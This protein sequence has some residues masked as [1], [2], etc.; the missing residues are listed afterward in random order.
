MKNVCFLLVLGAIFIGKPTQ[1]KTSINDG[2][3][4]IMQTKTNDS[5]IP[6]LNGFLKEEKYND[7]IEKAKKLEHVLLKNQQT[8]SLLISKI[9]HKKGY[10]F[11]QLEDYQSAINYFNE[12]INILPNAKQDSN[13]H[14]TILFDRSYAE[15]YFNRRTDYYKSLKK[16][17]TIISELEQPDYDFLLE[18]YAELSYETKYLGYFKEAETYLQKGYAIIKSKKN[19]TSKDVLFKH[20]AISLY[21]TWK[22]EAHILKHL[23]DLENLK[24]SKKFTP[25]ETLMY[26]VSLN[27]IADF[28]IVNLDRFDKND[29]LKKAEYYL[30]KAFKNLDKKH[31]KNSYIQ[32]KFNH[33]KLLLEKD[34]VEKVLKNVDELML[35]TK[36]T[37]TRR[38]F[39]YAMQAKVFFKTKAKNKSEKALFQMASA[40]HND[41]IQLHRDYS[42]FKPSLT[43]HHSWLLVELAD[44]FLE[45][46][47]NDT[48]I[49]KQANN[50]YKLGLLQF[51]NCYWQSAFN[52]LNKAGYSKAMFGILS[53][54]KFNANALINIL[55][56]IEN[57]E[58]RLAWK[59]FLNNRTDSNIAI[60]DSLRYKELQLRQTMVLA[61]QKNDQ[62]LYLTTKQKLETFNKLLN[63]NYP[64]IASFVYNNFS[65]EDFK[66]QLKPHQI[67]LRYKKFKDQF[68]VFII[69]KTDVKME[70]LPTTV[71]IDENIK[72][73]LENLSLLKV[74]K[75]SAKAL[76]QI[77][78][79][80][81]IDEYKSVIIIPDG[82]LHHLPFETLLTNSDKFLLEKHNISYASHL[83]FVN[84]SEAQKHNFENEL[85]VFS[86]TYNLN[87]ETNL[88]GATN[89]SKSINK[90]FK[91]KLFIGD[92]ALKSEF[93][94]NAQNANLLHLAM[95]ANL[96]DENPELSYF[97]FAENEKDNKMHLEELYA[98]SLN[99]ELAV[100]SACNTGK[101]NLENPE[102]AVSLKRAFVFAGVPATVSSLWQVPDKET[103]GLMV[104][105]YKNLNKGQYK[106]EALRN[107]K[108]NYLKTT[109]DKALKHP[110][111][112]AGFVVSGDVSAIE[113]PSN[114]TLIIVLIAL[115]LLGL[116][117]SR[118]KL[119][120]L[121]K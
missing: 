36:K 18:I 39:L 81:N 27:L 86:P 3:K 1:A 93:I 101:I 88:E 62:N 2:L 105:F 5:I 89:E 33:N 17:A 16:S 82:I 12:A 76:S 71:S 117:L 67:V 34:E 90:I 51:K 6:I 7:L 24:K 96:N 74:Y 43:L 110:F 77:L 60:P 21:C 11:Y 38:P 80:I 50:I 118:K 56:D 107:A 19:K 54:Q 73:Y 42:N 59:A 13:L 29:A 98:L 99:A 26:A 113:T 78:I 48:T 104:A 108:L 46:F 63:E 47:P 55:N 10:A 120:K 116:F 30:D 106:D 92:K 75:S 115:I 22:K 70:P 32:F 15:Y 65:V 72:N 35:L 14:G 9:R 66:K 28:Y 52:K 119:I 20:Y 31:N 44:E 49:V 87:D 4:T 91:G 109:D 45:A 95:H 100:L 53:T 41:S 111:Y 97:S 103:S 61:K 23:K 64:K 94:N 102:G 37:D 112:W 40:I 121:F 114:N 84:N 69:T 79:P 8:D 25:S 58:N 57:I 68:F 83:V 85:Y